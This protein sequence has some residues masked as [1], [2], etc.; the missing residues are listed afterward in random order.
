MRRLANPQRRRTGVTLIEMVLTIS[1]FS[2]LLAV[3]S[4]S[5]GSSMEEENLARTQELTR[6]RLDNG[7]ERVRELLVQTQ[8]DSGYPLVVP[9]AS[10]AV[11]H[12][13]I[14]LAVGRPLTDGH[15]SNALLY[16]QPADVDGD[17]WPDQDALGAV[18]MRPEVCAV[19]LVLDRD[20]TRSIV[21]VDADRQARRL[22]R[23]SAVP[24]LQFTIFYENDLE[25]YNPAPWVIQGRV[26]CNSDVDLRTWSP[27]TLD[28]NDFRTV[29]RVLGR[30]P[31]ASWFAFT[32]LEPRIRQWTLDPFDPSAPANDSEL[33]T[34]EDLA[35][36]GA[37][38]TGGIDSDFAGLDLNGDTDDLGELSSFLGESLERF[39]DSSAGSQ[40]TLQTTEHGV[41]RLAQFALPA[42]RLQRGGPEARRRLRGRG[43]PAASP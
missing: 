24:V 2:G 41:G 33:P 15:A 6:R 17:G 14:A 3:F 30:A 5:L 36:L 9:A 38:T 10:I 43:R 22:V 27:L 32:G 40:S 16:S 19:A 7:L 28:T 39:G 1:L 13:D 26:H 23:A 37:T 42:R 34:V 11:S 35:A 25:F 21:R 31:H 8:W 29:G 20:G 12:P 4:Q 18:V